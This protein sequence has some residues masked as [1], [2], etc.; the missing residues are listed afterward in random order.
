M[1]TMVKDMLKYVLMQDIIDG[2]FGVSKN[3]KFRAVK[4]LISN[5]LWDKLTRW[6]C[7]PMLK[8]FP[9]ASLNLYKWN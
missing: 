9:K 7:A 5:I 2:I 8:I 3:I 6:S 1:F 4:G